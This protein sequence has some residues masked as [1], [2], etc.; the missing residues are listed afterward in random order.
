V[1]P[2]FSSLRVD[3]L[4]L[5]CGFQDNAGRC[6]FFGVADV[7][8]IGSA[9]IEREII[10]LPLESITPKNCEDLGGLCLEV[11]DLF[12]FDRQN[13]RCSQSLQ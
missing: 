2:G 11:H 1:S 6:H 4:T 7:L 10:P 12:S 3:L 8:T 9:A 13:G 5:P